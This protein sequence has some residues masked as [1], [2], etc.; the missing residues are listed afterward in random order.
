MM[1]MNNVVYLKSHQ[2][3]S[4]DVAFILG[5]YLH[6]DHH[7]WHAMVELRELLCDIGDFKSALKILQDESPFTRPQPVTRPLRVIN[8]KI[9]F[10]DVYFEYGEKATAPVFENL[11]LTIQPGEKVGSCRP[12]WSRKIHT[13]PPAFRILSA[14]RRRNFN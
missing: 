1:A 8:A 4:A 5:I 2:M 13:H 9:E 3:I 14:P 6:M 11:T 10:Q 7:L 12:F